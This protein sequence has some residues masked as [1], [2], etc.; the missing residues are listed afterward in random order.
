VDFIADLLELVFGQHFNSAI[1][2]A[3]ADFNVVGVLNNF[4]KRLN[5]KPSSLLGV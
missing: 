5:C 1:W 2:M 4:E 3:N